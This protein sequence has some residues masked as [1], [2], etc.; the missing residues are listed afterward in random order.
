MTYKL[1]VV[2]P[3]IIE[4]IEF[5]EDNQPIP[6][7][8]F[9]YPEGNYRLFP[10][11]HEW[12]L[13]YFLRDFWRADNDKRIAIL[14]CHRIGAIVIKKHLVAPVDKQI[15][16]LG[17]YPTYFVRQIDKDPRFPKVFENKGV[18]IYEV[19]QVHQRC[20]DFKYW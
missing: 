14:N 1:R 3:E 10:V 19:P 7:T 18:V 16:N 6:R 13:G 5:L 4:A 12:Y 9:M 11:D 2:S 20:S 17:V 8:V 15:T